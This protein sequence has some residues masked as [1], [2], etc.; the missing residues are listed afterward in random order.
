MVRRLA[1]LFALPLL[2][3]SAGAMAAHPHHPA[4]RTIQARAAVHYQHAHKHP[5]PTLTQLRRRARHA[6]G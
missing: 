2:M 4:Q 5:R 1:P 3:L 6:H